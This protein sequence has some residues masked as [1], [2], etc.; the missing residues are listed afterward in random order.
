MAT[1]A[2]LE[3]SPRGVYCGAV[4]LLQPGSDPGPATGLT[5]R[6][7]VAIRTAVVDKV[8]AQVE[9]GSGGGI[10]WDSSPASEWEETLV[11]T[12]TL[13]KPALLLRDDGGLVETMRFDPDRAGDRE[14]GVRNLQGHL[15]RLAASAAYFGASFPRDAENRVA[16]AV[17]GRGA[18]AR[19]RLVLHLDGVMETQVSPLADDGPVGEQRLCVDLEPVASSDVA[20]FHKTTDRG[21][22]DARAR[23]HPCADDA[24]LINER[25]EVTETTRA[26][27]VVC[28][29]GR[30]WT[31]PLDCGLLP[32]VERARLLGCGY[33][34][35]RVVTVEQLQHAESV[36]TL[37]SLR[38]W[39]PARVLVGCTC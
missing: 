1:I 29:D 19:V 21:R 8:G 28:I 30:W 15:A 7:A 34:T 13:E 24:V 38:G 17:S 3:S 11:K 23:R 27:L 33:L 26:N 18:T 31:P 32:G 2:D 20:L 37:S 5:A 9:Y 36:A 16:A 14:Y 4:G 25:G 39:R 35:E 10:T 22:Y 12:R 6:F